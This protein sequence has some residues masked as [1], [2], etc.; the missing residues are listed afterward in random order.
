[1]PVTGAIGNGGRLAWRALPALL[2]LTLGAVFLTQVGT[3]HGPEAVY[4]A[5]LAAVLFA[6]SGY[7]LVRELFRRPAVPVAAT[8]STS[9]STTDPSAGTTDD[10]GDDASAEEPDRLTAGRPLAVIALLVVT[11]SLITPLGFFTV[12]PVLVIGALAITGVRRPLPLVVGGLCIWASAY[13][14]FGLLL[15]VPLPS[16]MW[17]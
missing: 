13:V 5:V 2:P 16:G 6:V 11:L 3:L 8:P 9:P 14:V 17:W 12:I 15:D 1:M 7:N 4:P 10:T